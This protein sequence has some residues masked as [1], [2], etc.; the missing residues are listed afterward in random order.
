MG[1]GSEN[2]LD[3]DGTSAETAARSHSHSAP[4][5]TATPMAGKV[6][7]YDWSEVRKHNKKDDAWIVVNDNVYDVTRF[8]KSHPGGSKILDFFSGQDAT[9][10][11]AHFTPRLSKFET[12]CNRYFFFLLI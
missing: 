11:A 6:T 7:F 8:K 10:A 1:K 2:K 12:L 5:L 4:I 3:E 9:V